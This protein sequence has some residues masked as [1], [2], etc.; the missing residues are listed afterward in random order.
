LVD[1]PEY[2]HWASFKPGAC[3]KTVNTYDQAF[4]GDPPGLAI[5]V[6]STIT[7]TKTLK[8]VGPDKVTV[9]VVKELETGGQRRSIPAKTDEIPAKVDKGK[10]DPAPKGYKV[11]KVEGDEE[12]A[13][14]GKTYKTHWVE[15]TLVSE[16]PAKLPDTRDKIWTSDQ[17]PG[18]M[19]KEI[20]EV[21]DGD[22]EKIE[23]AEFKAAS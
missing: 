1:N 19:I 9:E 10:L 18:G 13:V 6:T 4:R 23:L 11:T 2:K 3:V 12:I 14:G 8:E 15:Y 22:K 21:K 20:I 16:T 17:V 5:S 7:T